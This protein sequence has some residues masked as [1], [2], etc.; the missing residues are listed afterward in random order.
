MKLVIR[1]LQKK[2]VLES[3]PLW[4]TDSKWKDVREDEEDYLVLA[5]QLPSF[6]PRRG[7]IV[8]FHNCHWPIRFNPSKMSFRVYCH[9]SKSFTSITPQW[10][11]GVIIKDPEREVR[12]SEAFNPH[13]DRVKMEENGGS[14]HIRTIGET[15]SG[16]CQIDGDTQFVPLCNI[17]PF[18]YWQIFLSGLHS[19][20]FHP[21]IYHAMTLM[22]SLNVVGESTVS[23]TWPNAAVS[24]NGL[25]IGPELLVKGD[26]VRLAPRPLD[27]TGSSTKI[28]VTDIMVIEDIK[29]MLKDCEPDLLEENTNSTPSAENADEVSDS[30]EEEWEVQKI[31]DSRR[32]RSKIQ[33]KATY[34]GYDAWNNMPSWQPWTDFENCKEKVLSFHA[35]HPHKPGPPAFFLKKETSH[36][37]KSISICVEG[38][39][40]TIDPKCW[41]RR[42]FSPRHLQGSR[43]LIEAFPK[44]NI[45]GYA[46]WFQIHAPDEVLRV[47]PDGII[48][49]L[50]ESDYMMRMFGGLSMSYDLSG[51]L[52]GREYGRAADARMP[53]D[54]DWR[55][56]GN[57]ATTLGVT[58]SH[59]NTIA[60][61]ERIGVEPFIC[62]EFPRALCEKKLDNRNSKT[63]NKMWDLPLPPLS[64]T[65]MSGPVYLSQD[66]L[67]STRKR[68]KIIKRSQSELRR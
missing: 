54:K 68:G 22:T 45:H 28:P 61:Y 55:F 66:G 49:R 9:H 6:A 16:I 63:K 31:V 52:T 42:G 60:R 15:T 39:A 44:P 53:M 41:Q 7:E 36:V 32:Y 40:Y 62:E 5:S 47:S 37:C 19:K 30:D 27:P 2:G 10:K 14:F 43:E 33:Y 24:C 59:G 65:S 17:K 1:K 26:I 25:Y 11:A 57:R 3:H 35:R 38:R 12:F 23:G 4:T 67:E 46:N 8:L 18:S 56:S 21:S 29:V 13:V 48:G 34:T 50:H 58:A 64:D 20:D 51:V